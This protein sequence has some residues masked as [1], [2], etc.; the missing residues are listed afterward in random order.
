MLLP[1][2]RKRV[3][4]KRPLEHFPSV[5]G[6]FVILAGAGDITTLEVSWPGYY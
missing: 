6:Q 1:I 5:T 2:N 4:I 3:S